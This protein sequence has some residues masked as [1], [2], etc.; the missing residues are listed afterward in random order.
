MSQALVLRPSAKVNLT[1]RVGPRR[2]DGYHDV[3]TL[4]QSIGLSDV[5]TLTPRSGPFG[6]MS[7]SP[8]VPADRTNLIWR[9]AELLWRA[10]GRAG[11]P[12]DVHVKL[13]KQIPA[14]A[15][16]GGGSADAA[17]ALVGLNQVWGGRQS[18]RHL[19]DLAAQLGSDVPFFLHG[20]TALGLGRG[21]ELYPV[22]D[23]A[24]LGVVVIKPSFGVGTAEAYGWLDGDR[25]EGLAVTPARRQELEV[26]WAGGPIVLGNDLQA[27]VARRHPAIDE[28]VAACVSQGAMAAAMSGSGSAVYGVFAETTAR[29]AAARLQR[30]DWLVL[31][32]RTLTRREAARRLGL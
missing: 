27:P 5:V 22:D 28:M 3:H 29:R 9:A 16:L 7:R 25:A 2:E 12:R 30:P 10:M 32:T 1:L 14:A 21:E 11:E 18:R 6:L 31:L 15:G 4:M 26:G 17:A 13:E 8:G 19:I 20:G 24:R 23:V